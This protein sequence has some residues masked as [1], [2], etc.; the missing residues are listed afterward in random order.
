[1]HHSTEKR[2]STD[3]LYDA[4]A[5]DLLNV[6]DDCKEFVGVDEEVVFKRDGSSQ[7]SET[8]FAVPQ[9]TTLYGSHC[10]RGCISIILNNCVN[11]LFTSIKNSIIFC[12]V[13]CVHHRV[14]LVGFISNECNHHFGLPEN[15]SYVMVE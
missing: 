4:D 1:L 10:A 11:A 6:T 14:A 15:D 13:K 7:W 5:C 8:V 2:G 3:N 9:K 12:I